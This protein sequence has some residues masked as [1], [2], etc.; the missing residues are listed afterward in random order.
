MASG[1]LIVSHYL[2]KK[3]IKDNL[4]T[5][6]K[7]QFKSNFF[8]CKWC[9]CKSPPQINSEGLHK[10]NL[11]TNFQLR[12]TEGTTVPVLV[13]SIHSC[14]SDCLQQVSPLGVWH[15]ITAGGQRC[16]SF[17]SFWLCHTTHYDCINHLSP[18]VRQRGC[19]LL[20]ST[21]VLRHFLRSSDSLRGNKE[22]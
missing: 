2:K 4:K 16:H 21:S 15:I 19:R 17:G 22:T 9:L 7:R 14:A 8:L 3:N 6:S 20:P 18:G 10:K 1:H 13:T 12:V 11:Y 5:I